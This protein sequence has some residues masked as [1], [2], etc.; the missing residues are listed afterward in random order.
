[1]TRK[2]IGKILF[3]VLV[4]GSLLAPISLIMNSAADSEK[5]VSIEKFKVDSI[6]D[7]S[8]A[9]TEVTKVLYNNHDQAVDEMF[10]FQLPNKAFISNFSLTVE[11]VTHYAEVVPKKEAEER[12]QE[13]VESG[14]N[15]GLL[16]AR[17][18]TL[19]TYSIN[20]KPKET[21]SIGLRYEEYIL[22]Q[23]GTYS[24]HVYLN[25]E[26]TKR[27]IKELE[28]SVDIRSEMDFTNLEIENHHIETDIDWDNEKSVSLF[29]SKEDTELDRDFIVNY[30]TQPP[31][32]DGLML[33]YHNGEV[34]YFFHVFSPQLDD[35]GEP[36]DKDIIFVLDKSGSMGGTKIM[37]LKEAFSEIVDQLP[38]D[39]SFNIIEFDGN[40]NQYKSSSVKA[41]DSEKEK[42]KDH[43]ND[44]SAGGSTNI[45]EALLKGLKN[46]DTNEYRAPII[47]FLTDGQPTAGVTDT[48][49]IRENIMNSNNHDTAIFSLGFGNYVDFD[50]LE[51]LSLENFGYAKRIYEAQDAALQ[52]T[53]FYSLISTPLLRNLKFTYSQ[54]TY[55]VYD[56][57]V[58]H[59]WEGSETVIV[60]KYEN[61][62]KKIGSEVKAQSDGGEMEFSDDFYLSGDQDH[63]FIERFW[64][65]RRINYLL[66]EIKVQG[67]EDSLVSEVIDL[68][69][70][71]NFVTP[72]TSLLIDIEEPD[73][74]Q[75]NEQED[76]YSDLV[77]VDSDSAGSVDI[78]YS[79]SKEALS[80]SSFPFVLLILLGIIIL[81][82]AGTVRFRNKRKKREVQENKEDL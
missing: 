37:Q 76:D 36:L 42:A 23:R 14:R 40:I 2:N 74:S 75:D 1:M 73:E 79:G 10:Y 80:M 62:V 45:N 39:D 66:D 54:G 18:T 50:F 78:Y 11:G 12:Y 61:G 49:K 64:A 47:I 60:G 53:D 52:I 28:I 70:K 19:F 41:K 30:Q 33:N 55:D 15:A 6:I 25:T 5:Y 68:S 24:Y 71:Y 34:G 63:P 56:T 82:S 22:K 31:P 48:N 59:L 21:V 32:R 81:G 58:G 65:Y 29:Y 16:E 4:V 17:D 77:D 51:A 7:S 44:I 38:K 13:A 8:Y 35:I 20:C 27:T 72:Y 3:C 43:I 69:V 67:E 46:I 9:V 57:S 26:S